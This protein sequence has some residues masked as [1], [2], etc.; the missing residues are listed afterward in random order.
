[1]YIKTGD[2]VEVVA[3][4]D[5]GKTGRI[6]RVDRKRDRVVVQGLNLVTRNQKPNQVQEGGR[7]TKEASLHVSNV[8]LYSEDDERGFRIGFRYE[9]SDESLYSTRGEAAAIFAETPVR[10]NKVRVFLK[11]EGKTS[12]VPNPQKGEEV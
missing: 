9:G 10:V 1:M 12:R 4:K 2:M 5:S 7:I 6:L 3:G 11:G 8:R